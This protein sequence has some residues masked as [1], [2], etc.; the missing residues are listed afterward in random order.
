MKNEAATPFEDKLRK[1]LEPVGELPLFSQD[2]LDRL[3]EQFWGPDSRGRD[4]MFSRGFTEETL[5][6][7]KIGY[8]TK[9]DMISTP[10]F[11]VM[12]KP[13]GLIGRSADPANKVFKNS[14]RL[15][16][17]KTLWNIHKA[18][19]LGETVII[20]EAN[21]DAMRI[22]QAGFP[23]VVACLGGNFSPYHVEQLDKYFNHIIIMTDFD[24]KEKHKYVGC[25]KCARL[26]LPDCIGHNPGR[27]LGETISEL[28]VR[29]QISWA[30]YEPGIVYPP[31]VKDADDMTDEQIAQ[32]IKNAASNYSYHTWGIER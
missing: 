12:G 4:Y 15:P 17:S 19:R 20:C 18:K 28:M 13:L 7:Y 27:A 5:R 11:D 32:C 29:K 6:E 9:Q 23:N 2:T 16:T 1:A 3:Y 21:F 26:G 14:T 22:A 24:D 10:M 31:G 30:S 8:S 25:R